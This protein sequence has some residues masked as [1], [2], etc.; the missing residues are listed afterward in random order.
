M[1]GYQKTI[2]DCRCGQRIIGEDEDDLVEKALAHLVEKHPGRAYSRE[3]ILF[4]AV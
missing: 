4:M 1:T 2:V 3:Q